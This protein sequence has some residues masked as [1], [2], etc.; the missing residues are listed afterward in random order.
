MIQEIP[1]RTRK[2]VHEGANRPLRAGKRGAFPGPPLVNKK[3]EV[4]RIEK[5]E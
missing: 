1:E 3:Y 4:Q 5:K 2:A